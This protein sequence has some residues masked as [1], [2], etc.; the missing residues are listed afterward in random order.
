L[1]AAFGFKARQFGQM[2]SVDEVMAV[3][4]GV[5]SVEAVNVLH[6]Y[7]PDQGATPRLEPRLFARLPEASLSALPQAAELLLLDSGPIVL[8]EMA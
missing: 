4:H 7:R 6:L 3:L 1:R 8:E 5:A 2:V